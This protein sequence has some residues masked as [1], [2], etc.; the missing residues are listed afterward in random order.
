VAARPWEHADQARAAL[1]AIITDPG[2]GLRALSSESQAA[3][4]LEDL[5][6]DAPRERAILVMAAKA[7]LAQALHDYAA[8]GLDAATAMNLTAASFEETSPL[9]PQACRWVVTELAVALGLIAPGR[10]GADTAATAASKTPDPAEPVRQAPGFAAGY[11]TRDVAPA[12]VTAP[13][14]AG[15]VSPRRPAGGVPARASSHAQVQPRSGK[16]RHRD[17]ADNDVAFSPDGLLLGT[18]GYDGIARTWVVRTGTFASRLGEHGGPVQSVTFS[19]DGRL[20][21]TASLADTA[22][23]WL[24]STGSLVRAITSG[25]AWDVA[26]SPDGLLLAT[27]GGRTAPGVASAGVD[28]AAWLWDVATGKVVAGVAG[29][30]GHVSAVAF[31]PD[32]SLLATAGNGDVVRFWDVVAG[33]T[34]GCLPR[35]IGRASSIAFSPDGSLLAT[36]GAGNV[37]RLWDVATGGEVRAVTA[38]PARDVAF[39]P[40]GRLLATAGGGSKP[41]PGVAA[42]VATDT[43]AWL[44][45]IATGRSAGRLAG[46]GD[47]VQAIAFSHAGG[48]CATSSRD[49]TTRLWNLTS[50]SSVPLGSSEN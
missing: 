23:L 5:L 6:P 47:A 19:R 4:A 13:R 16:K 39:S 41:A 21:A 22:R 42:A 9:D 24:V 8:Q 44:W 30:S 27:A 50:G 3:N 48:L 18:A 36:A 46:H 31:S 15:G 45:D 12:T 2:L 33:R 34:V 32:G 35:R 7:R 26:F 1:Q 14:V 28:E 17:A 37:T 10:Q 11:P 43:A 20:A 25:P 49:R 29:R 38:Q 40:D